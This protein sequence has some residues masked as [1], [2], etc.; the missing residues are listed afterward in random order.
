MLIGG[1]V[2]GIRRSARV[3]Q[4][5]TGTGCPDISG[6]AYRGAA[7]WSESGSTELTFIVRDKHWYFLGKEGHMLISLKF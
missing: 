2:T 5:G 6:E 7:P 1:Q 3:G 4:K